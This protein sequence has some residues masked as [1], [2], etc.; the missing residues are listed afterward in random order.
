MDQWLE[1]LSEDWVSQPQSPHSSSLHNSSILRHTPSPRSNVSQS[2]IPRYNPRSA[3]NLSTVSGE[4]LGQPKLLRRGNSNE[5]ALREKTPSNLNASHKRLP[6]GQVKFQSLTPGSTKQRGQHTSSGSLA[7]GPQGTVHHKLSPVKQKDEGETPEWKRRVL[8]DNAGGDLFSPIGL[9]NVFKPLKV[10]SGAERKTTRRRKLLP[11]EDIPSSP[12]PLAPTPP[13]KYNASQTDVEE[14]IAAWPPANELQ[15]EGQASESLPL[16]NDVESLGGNPTKRDRNGETGPLEK[17]NDT[18]VS[19]TATPSEFSTL[20]TVYHDRPTSA[21][22]RSR[23]AATL[24][25]GSNSGI[26]STHDRSRNENISPLYVSRHNTV[27][28]RV[29]YGAIDMSMQQLR[30][31]MDRLRLQQ[32]IIPSSR[33]SDPG[34]GD[35]ES[36]PSGRSLLCSQMDEVTSQS[37]PDDLSMGTD[38]Y[39]ANGGFV[40]IHRGG[41]SNDGS[42]QRRPVSPSLL[43]DPDGPSLKPQTSTSHRAIQSPKLPEHFSQTKSKT[44]SSSPQTPEHEDA[45]N[46]GSYE[47]PKSSGSPLKLFDKY[48]TFTNDRLARRMSKFEQTLNQDLQAESTHEPSSPSPRRRR[49]YKP[50][51]APFP[52]NSPKDSSLSNFGAGELDDHKFPVHQSSD[53]NLPLEQTRQDMTDLP[54][55][56][57]KSKPKRLCSNY[58]EVNTANGVRQTKENIASTKRRHAKGLRRQDSQN[59]KKEPDAVR[60]VTGKRTPHSPFKDPAPK[61]RRTLQTS[62]DPDREASQ[63]EHMEIKELPAQYGHG[64]KRKDALYNSDRRAADPSTMAKRQIL[65]P[66]GRVSTQIASVS[67]LREPVDANLLSSAEGGKQPSVQQPDQDDNL[68]TDPPT[69][70]VAGAL[71]SVALSTVRDMTYGSRQASLT[72]ADFYLEAQQIMQQIRANG[73]PRSSHTTT[74]GSEV[75][76]LTT[77]EESLADDSTKDQFSRPP[78]REGGTLPRPR[79]PMQMDARVVSHLRKF[80]DGEDLGLALSSS[81]KILQISRPLKDSGSRANEDAVDNDRDSNTESYPPDIRIRESIAQS[82]ERERSSSTRDAS[83]WETERRHQS[84]GSQTSSGPSSSRSDP[85][86]SSRSST[87]RMIIAPETVAHLLSDQ[88]AGMVFDHQRQLWVKRKSSPNVGGM[89]SVDQSASEGTEEDLLGDIPDL[90]VNEME[91]LQRVKDAMSSIKS[92]G[93]AADTIST[94]SPAELAEA[95]LMRFA[96]H[97]AIG[98]TRPRTAH[99]KCIEVVENS[100]A[101]SKYTH[102]TSSGPT[103]GTRATS[104]GNEVP[105]MKEPQVHTVSPQRI[106]TNFK[107]EHAEEVEHEISILEGRKAP[108]PK[109]Q[110]KQRQARVVTVAFSSPL[111]DQR[112]LPYQR[113]DCSEAWDEGSELDLSE[114]PTIHGSRRK[115]C[116]TRCTSFGILTKSV[117]RKASRRVS[118]G[119]QSYLARP[120]SRLDEQEELSLVQFSADDRRITMEVTVSTPLPQSRSLLL[121]PPTT[122]Q[123]SSFGFRLTPLSDFT[124]NQVDKPIDLNFSQVARKHSAEGQENDNKLSIAAQNLVEKLTDLQPY[125]PYW[126]HLRSVDLHDRDLKTLH[127]LDEF[128]GSVEELDVS[129][130]WIGELDGIPYTVRSLSIRNNC[131]SDLAAWRSLQNLQYLDVSGNQLKSL[132]GFQGL[133]H[134]RALKAEQNELESLNGLERLDG[135][136]SLSLR[137]NKLRTVN[138]EDHDLRR[139]ANID[140]RGNELTEVSNLHRLTALETCDLSDNVL[141]A[142][143]FPTSKPLL[144]LGFLNVA[145]NRLSFVDLAELPNLKCLN[146]D[147]NS[148]ALIENVDSLKH[149]ESL[150]WRK[151]TL[152]SAYGFSE[153]QYQHCNEVRN[154]YMS[155]NYL[156][157]F[158]PPSP[159]L[160]L[161]HLELASTG[162]QTFSPE[163]G[164]QCPNL[165]VLNCNYNAI[166]DLR[167]LLGI[168][169]LEKLFLAGNRVSRL[170]R[171]VGVLSLLGKS[172]VEVDIRNNPLTVGFYTPQQPVHPERSI[173]L[174][175]HSRTEAGEEDVEAKR[176]EAYLLPQFDTEQDDAS[177]E[178]LD[179]DTKMRRR[180][181][182]VM[183][184][185]AC[186]H[187][188][189]LNGLEVDKKILKKDNCVRKRLH[190]LG[191]LKE[192]IMTERDDCNE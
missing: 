39:A 107:Q 126:D 74:E 1:S 121:P 177:R 160:N 132:K 60:K 141:E 22:G 171:T 16:Q 161:R 129:D 90:S 51:Q 190:E 40:S 41:Y 108:T 178:R 186:K 113:D 8:I 188:E 156:S 86:G 175:R 17:S 97:E 189:R 73:R 128:C 43:P 153:V 87:R 103:P 4:K 24:G 93:S 142:L 69:R 75:D 150:S 162:L 165:R 114:S 116:S 57:R 159:F 172:L 112:E 85:S 151:H 170:R 143:D 89:G 48:D 180:V 169:K 3:S 176:R 47:R 104:W 119:N 33:S 54:P 122:S 185:H 110:N 35:A 27:D 6:N 167:P 102:F 13:Q 123:Q 118:I 125:E 168:R 21:L 5:H 135:L 98:N 101:P 138:F 94:H 174:Q 14:P 7:P 148:I 139:L 28:G 77:V 9:E 32:Q 147:G 91:E 49:P 18:V 192:K 55:Q 157:V 182:E 144:K 136:I 154:L 76:R 92:F 10:K 34:I 184:A 80:K 29:E 30:T 38:A 88:M 140:L 59:A 25:D 68:A 62:D 42:F 145:S 131:L 20:P 64:R 37:L 84:H 173:A 152:V 31:E 12:P 146:L 65:Q 115:P 99:G 120:M 79:E 23:I 56:R 2:R 183:I 81:L 83:N 45:R 163:L 179:E 66:R 11:V 181:L 15:E 105:S 106:S 96:D 109:H 52:F 149:L 46:S 124:L 137:G 111:V 82:H 53:S 71:A 117:Q 187:L 95:Q 191:V 100:S 19:S 61:R 127:M 158:A 166:R 134:L 63:A 44:P 36:R 78:S 133:V 50:A 130:N 58:S 155:G 26:S 70:I 164:V 72:T 67:N